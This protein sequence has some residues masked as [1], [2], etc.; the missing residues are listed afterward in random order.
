MYYYNYTAT[1]EHFVLVGSVHYMYM[2]C[3]CTKSVL[4]VRTV[5]VKGAN[6]VYAI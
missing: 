5:A 1:L 4:N 6:T 2:L 3:L